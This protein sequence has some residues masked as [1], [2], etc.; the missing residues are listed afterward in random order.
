MSRLLVTGA[1]REQRE[2][3]DVPALLPLRVDSRNA[4]H[5]ALDREKDSIARRR[6]ITEH[7]GEVRAK[8]PGRR[9]DN[10][11]ECE[12]LEPARCAHPSCSGASR[13]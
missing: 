3:I 4:V 8:Q 5:H 13:A 11:D 10:G 2:R 9:Q 7:S 12:Q 6:T 1:E